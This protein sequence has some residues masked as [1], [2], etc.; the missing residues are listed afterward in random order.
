[1][2]LLLRNSKLKF[3]VGPLLSC[4]LLGVWYPFLSPSVKELGL[5]SP[6][7]PGARTLPY[8]PSGTLSSDG[9]RL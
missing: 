6:E 8:V 3:L 2:M 4:I 9:H 5:S 7:F 1:M